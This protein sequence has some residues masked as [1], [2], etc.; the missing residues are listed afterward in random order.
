MSIITLT[1]DFG[2]RD[3]Y[4]G[5]MKGR[6]LSLHPQANIMDITHDIEPQGI[7]EAAWSLYRS[8]PHFPSSTIHVAVIDPGVG[9]SRPAVVLKSADHWYVGPDNG[10]FSQVYRHF[11]AQSIT[12]LYRQTDWWEAHA[13]FDGL[14][15]FAPVAACLANSVPLQKMGTP[16]GNLTLIPSIEPQV[17]DNLI[18]GQII[19]FDR[20]GNAITN[21]NQEHLS[22][23]H[24]NDVAI[25]CK[26]QSLRLVNHYQEGDSNGMALINSD[27][28]L[29]LAVFNASARKRL[30]FKV[31]D[32]VIVQYER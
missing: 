22:I 2:T 18:K 16:M 3:G 32:P 1:T 4:V 10:V 25:T 7:L 13:S 24:R 8:T 20:F 14:A 12:E 21:I 5:A 31:G 23:L 11:G 19:M 29:E 26:Q 6:I 15:L 30:K 9:S 28:L 27:H 17:E